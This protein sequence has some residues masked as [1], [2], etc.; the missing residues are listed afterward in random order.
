MRCG[1]DV[2]GTRLFQ[3]E[4]WLSKSQIKGFFSRLVAAKRKKQLLEQ[5]KDSDAESEDI[6]CWVE[7]LSAAEQ[8]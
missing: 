1:K 2:N 4:Q 5:S 3:K 7:E 6:D 8:E